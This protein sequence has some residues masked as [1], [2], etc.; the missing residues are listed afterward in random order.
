MPFVPKVGSNAPSAANTFAAASIK[1]ITLAPPSVRNIFLRNK[2][3]FIF[4]ILAALLLFQKLTG[5]F[6]MIFGKVT[7]IKRN[8]TYI[9][10]AYIT[11]YKLQLRDGLNLFLE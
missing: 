6:Q 11:G 7:N 4:F 8:F 5:C 9:V 10:E 1:R 2:L 3:A